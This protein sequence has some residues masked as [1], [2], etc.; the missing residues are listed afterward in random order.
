MCV[1]I[2]SPSS[3][4]PLKHCMRSRTPCRPRCLEA[5]LHFLIAWHSL[6]AWCLRSTGIISQTKGAVWHFHPKQVKNVNLWG[7]M[8]ASVNDQVPSL[9]LWVPGLVHPLWSLVGHLLR[10]SVD[11]LGAAGSAGS[12]PLSW[13]N[14]SRKSQ[15][16][17]FYLDLDNL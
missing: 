4:A 14:N 10:S 13:V 9:E 3:D 15:I 8:I 5:W 11:P 7:R 12:W 17:K 6:F 2:L 1:C 16:T